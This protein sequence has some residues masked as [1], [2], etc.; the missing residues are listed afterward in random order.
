M[1]VINKKYIKTGRRKN[2]ISG[3]SSKNKKLFENIMIQ[4]NFKNKG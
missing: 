3:M 1:K 2:Q 4:V